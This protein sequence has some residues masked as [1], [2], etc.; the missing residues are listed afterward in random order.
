MKTS[1]NKLRGVE[2][3]TGAGG[4]AMGLE[5]AGF[6]HL[7]AIEWDHDSCETIRENQK[8]GFGLV[9]DWKLYECDVRQFDYGK[10]KEPID[11]VA[12]GPPCQPF[13]L[14]GKHGAFNDSRDMWSEAV[15]HEL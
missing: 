3:F 8:R 11:L 7:A 1:S 5:L 2:L 13:S 15:R 4:L 9:K 10:I 12:G 6:K 14:A